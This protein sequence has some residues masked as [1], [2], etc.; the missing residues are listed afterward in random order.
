LWPRWGVRGAGEGGPARGGDA[1]LSCSL[2]GLQR[3]EDHLVLVAKAK[4]RGRELV[5]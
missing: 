4:E 2:M 5:S 1:R 3:S